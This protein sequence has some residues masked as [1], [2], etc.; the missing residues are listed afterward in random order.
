M[1]IWEMHI[2]SFSCQLQVEKPYK[3]LCVRNMI[4]QM[5]MYRFPTAYFL[6]DKEENCLLPWAGFTLIVL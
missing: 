4:L 6:Q 3:L 1:S 2:T 5:D